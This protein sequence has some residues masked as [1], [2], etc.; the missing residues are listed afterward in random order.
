[1]RQF[2]VFKNPNPRSAKSVPYLVL[3]QHGLLSALET[4][5]MV[6]LVP[7]V[8]LGKQPISR[9]NPVFKVDGQSLALLAQQAGAVRTSSL[10][11]AVANL[12]AHRSAIVG[13]IDVVL[14]G[15]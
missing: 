5:L 1:M 7:V 2:D 6:P 14:G 10:G 13:A 11:K 9:L 4:R 3:V 12:E 8:A 15:V